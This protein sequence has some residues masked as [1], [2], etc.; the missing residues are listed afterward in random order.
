[1]KNAI[2]RWTT[3][4]FVLV[5][6]GAYLCAWVARLFYRDGKDGGTQGEILL[7]IAVLVVVV[8]VWFRIAWI[9]LGRDRTD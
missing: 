1:M 6:F 7:G 2:R 5:T 8:L 3:G 9:W 4:Q